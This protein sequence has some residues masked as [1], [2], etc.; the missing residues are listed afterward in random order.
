MLCERCH[1]REATCHIVEMAVGVEQVRDFCAECAEVS[2]SPELKSI[3]DQ[4]KDAVCEFCGRSPAGTSADMFAL[5]RAVSRLRHMCLECSQ[6]Y[7]RF[8]LR[9]LSGVNPNLSQAEQLNVLTKM[10][11]EADSDMRNWTKQRKA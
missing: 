7:H 4:T 6:E 10:A 2:A 1:N 3:L 8:V 9:S 11:T 5:M